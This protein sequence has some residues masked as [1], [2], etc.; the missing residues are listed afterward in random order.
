MGDGCVGSI[1]PAW[2]YL[3]CTV[4]SGA[5]HRWWL[6][7]LPFK[8]KVIA[9]YIGFCIEGYRAAIGGDGVGYLDVGV[10][11]YGGDGI[12]KTV[13]KVSA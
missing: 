11:C 4:C 1:S 3:R 13:N 7:P 10:G 2:Y 8:R 6:A 5:C 12:R 9:F